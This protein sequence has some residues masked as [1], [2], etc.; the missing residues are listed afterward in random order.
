MRRLLSTGAGTVPCFH[1]RRTERETRIPE[2][3]SGEYEFVA[4]DPPQKVRANYRFLIENI[5]DITHLYLL[6]DG[7]IGNLSNSFI[8]AEGMEREHEGNHS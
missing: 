7:N 8:P 1:S 5:L 4:A 6:H 3:S 2:L